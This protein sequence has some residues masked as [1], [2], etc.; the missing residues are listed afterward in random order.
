VSLGEPAADNRRDTMTNLTDIT[1]ANLTALFG[2]DPLTVEDVIEALEDDGI[3]AVVEW[4][5]GTMGAVMAG[6]VLVGVERGRWFIPRKVRES[7]L[8]F[9]VR[10]GTK[11][12]APVVQRVID[13]LKYLVD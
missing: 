10:G 1:D 2:T 13:S 5:G 8:P 6:P 7:F 4:G 12:E 3:E 9:G 11:G